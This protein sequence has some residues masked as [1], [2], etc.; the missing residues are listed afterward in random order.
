MPLNSNSHVLATKQYFVIRDIKIILIV[1]HNLAWTISLNSLYD[2][3][4]ICVNHLA[5]LLSAIIIFWCWIGASLAVF[6]DCP[7]FFDNCQCLAGILDAI[8]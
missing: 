7:G 1:Y 8:T 3:T 2:H 5:L 4:F 6:F